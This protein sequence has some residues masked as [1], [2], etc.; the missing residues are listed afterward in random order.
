MD[1][2]SVMLAA[3]TDYAQNEISF[4]ELVNLSTFFAL[5]DELLLQLE[6]HVH[7][8]QPVR[9]KAEDLLLVIAANLIV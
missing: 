4:Y 2:R 6:H 3:V 9:Q 7:V 5:S 8:S 1:H